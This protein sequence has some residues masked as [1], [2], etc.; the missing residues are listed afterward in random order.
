[1]MVVRLATTVFYLESL[2][3]GIFL[4]ELLSGTSGSLIIRLSCF[5]AM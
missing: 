5:H 3:V 2:K 1:M 4:L